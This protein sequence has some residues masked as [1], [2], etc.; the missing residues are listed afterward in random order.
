MPPKALHWSKMKP[1]VTA[2]QRVAF[3]SACQQAFRGVAALE[4]VSDAL[5]VSQTAAAHTLA[6]ED[7]DAT[8]A[9]AFVAFDAYPTPTTLPKCHLC[10]A[11][12]SQAMLCNAFSDWVVPLCVRCKQRSATPL[13][14]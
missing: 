2:Q 11:E 14:Q 9:R 7:V 13:Q 12:T 4:T 8:R 6:S 3:L 10:A 1:P 5:F